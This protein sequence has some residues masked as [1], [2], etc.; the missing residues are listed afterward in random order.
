MTLAP[1]KK[2]YDQPTEHIKKQR[3]YFSD[4]GLSS[5]SY[6]FSSSHVWMWELDYKESWVLKT[7]CFWIVVLEKTLE[8]PLHCKEI[9]PVPTDF[10]RKS[11]LNIHWKDWCWSW[12]SNTLATW[13]K[14]I[15]WKRPWCWARLKAGG[16]GDDREWDGWMALPTRWTWVW[17]DSRSWWWAGRPG[18]LQ[19][20]QSQ[21]VGHWAT[22]LNWTL[23][24]VGIVRKSKLVRNK[25]YSTKQLWWQINVLFTSAQIAQTIIITW[26]K[27]EMVSNG[28]L[29]F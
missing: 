26:L 25:S 27:R 15:H 6:G 24:M 5:Q 13:C 16:E 19:S 28:S 1:W 12:N 4:K 17:V 21:R 22:E 9:Q 29:S 2:S 11:V 10:L 3:H 18:V 8:S 23:L 7:W 14:L 20:M